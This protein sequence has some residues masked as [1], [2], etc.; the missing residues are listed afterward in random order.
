MLLWCE[1][2][3]VSSFGVE[4]WDSV[5]KRSGLDER[6][7]LEPVQQPD[8]VPRTCDM[9]QSAKVS[10][11]LFAATCKETGLSLED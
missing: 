6:T 5:V 8:D 11:Q 9:R 3:I 7:I 1:D 4:K 2:L 10:F